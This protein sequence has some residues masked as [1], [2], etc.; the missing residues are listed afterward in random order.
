MGKG[1]ANLRISYLGGGYDFPEFFKTHQVTIISESTSL[2]IVCSAAT[3]K[4]H[5]DSLPG[6]GKGLGSSAAKTVAMIRARYPDASER[7]QTKA[8]IQL[9]KLQ[10]GG[11]Q[12]PIASA[13]RKGIFLINLFKNDW[14]VKFPFHRK[15]VSALTKYR[16]LYKI[17]NDVMVKKD[18]ILTDMQNRD[19]CLERMQALVQQGIMA[20]QHADIPDFGRTVQS[21]WEIKKMWHP[22]ISSPM[23][24]KMCTSA[25][26]SGAWG[27]K[28]CGAGGQGYLLVIG[29]E[30]C[31]EKMQ[32]SWD[33]FEVDGG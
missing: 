21:A 17:P 25:Q 3:S 26:E 13:Q 19:M 20:L 29:S 16:R 23:I 6:L 32:V 14:Q 28:V 24:E 4:L 8:A 15:C 22:N 2:Q 33:V 12:D 10:C 31:H 27:W 30:A 11:W 1:T 9:E 7:E 18:S 5:W